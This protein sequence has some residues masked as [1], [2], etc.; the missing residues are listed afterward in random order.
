[1][2]VIGQWLNSLAVLGSDH[3]HND[4]SWRIPLITQL[5]PPSLLLLSYFILPESPTWLLMH[6]RPDEAAK[7]Y[8]RYNGPK[9]DVDGALAVARLAIAQEQDAK[10]Q[11]EGSRWIDC[12]RGTNGRRTLI[13]IMV[14]L[15][16]QFIGV[17]FI[18]GYLTYYFRLAGVTDPLAVGQGAYAIQ[19]AGN[20]TSW[21][22]VDRYGRRPMILGGAFSMT[23]LLLIIGGV[24][25]IKSSSALA[26]T[27]ALMCIW[28]Y[29][30]QMTL[31]AVAYSVGGETSR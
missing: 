31:G 27:V 26:G 1:M 28:G 7:S 29:I 15:S 18:S 21:F 20:I 10:K 13:I 22:L 9:F 3:Y 4:L 11:Q 5:I 17:N 2:I 6:G 8:R 19:L 30:Y 24:S 23:G 16:Q 25:T 12:F 14:Y